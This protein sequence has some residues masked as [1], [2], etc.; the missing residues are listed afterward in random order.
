M[1]GPAGLPPTW[2]TSSELKSHEYSGIGWPW[3]REC[4]G[5]LKTS[6]LPFFGNEVNPDRSVVGNSGIA[7][8]LA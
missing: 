1:M 4:E 6:S 7:D 2:L 3:Q 5:S 8:R